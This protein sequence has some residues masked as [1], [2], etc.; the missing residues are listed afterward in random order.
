MQL[1]IYMY[2]STLSLPT[3]F[4]VPSHLHY[5]CLL[6]PSSHGHTLLA[7]ACL[8]PRTLRLSL[9]TSYPNFPLYKERMVK[10]EAVRETLCT[11]AWLPQTSLFQNPWLFPGKKKIKFSSPNKHKMSDLLSASGYNLHSSFSLVHEDWKVF[12]KFPFFIKENLWLRSQWTQMVLPS[13]NVTKTAVYIVSILNDFSPKCQLFLTQNKIPWA[14]R[15]FIFPYHFLIC[16]MGCSQRRSWGQQEW[17]IVSSS[18][19]DKSVDTFEQNK[20][21]LSASFPHFKNHLF[22]W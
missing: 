21:F 14:L 2:V 3:G 18:I 9:H 4:P 8:Q 7:R 22:C 19:M 16:G 17:Q 6:G 11:L 1:R 12:H 20:R 15:Y 13:F 5:L 10:R